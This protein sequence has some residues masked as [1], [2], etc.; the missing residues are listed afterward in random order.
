M[1]PH[2]KLSHLLDIKHL[3]KPFSSFVHE[4]YSPSQNKLGTVILGL[5]VGAQTLISIFWINVFSGLGEG[6]AFMVMFPYAYIV[7]S[8]ASLLIFY[9][10]KRTSYFTF[11]QLAMLLVM[12]FFM[13]WIIGGFAA[14]SSIAI[15]AI[16]S[17]VGALL[18]L[19][20]RQS[21]AWFALFFVL[22][23]ASWF[24]NGTFAHFAPTIPERIRQISFLVNVGGVATILYFVMRYFQSQTEKAM[25]ALVIEQGKTDKLLLNILPKVIA[26]RLKQSSEKI[27]DLYESVTILF[28]DIV[29]FTT[30]SAGMSPDDLVDILSRV[31]SRFDELVEKHGV[32]KIKTIG[33]AYMVVSGAPEP[34][35]N[36]AVAIAELAL[37]MEKALKEMSTESTC[38]MMRIGI[39]SGPVV[40]GV[41]GSSKF[42]YD[43]WGDTVNMA[44]R[45]ESYGVPERIQV[46]QQ[47]YELL[48]DHYKFEKREPIE[49]KGKGIVQTYLLIEDETATA[50][51][52]KH[53][54]MTPA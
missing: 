18:L 35:M 37:D 19:G 47:A 40:A 43:M 5:M 42:S 14:S 51:S 39:N 7:V 17:P 12:P 6:Y 13:Q 36:H 53:P 27:A 23:I 1:K 52:N 48:K 44:S 9:R 22:T 31:F 41:I 25:Y 21:T 34:K 32:E 4:M 30:L 29:G 8:Y 2:S 15:W 54:S 46:T 20:T 24:L 26:D 49:V 50:P 45:M 33:D 38:L 16:L 3:V 10:L 11:T 28:A